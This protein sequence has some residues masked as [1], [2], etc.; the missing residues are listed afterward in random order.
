MLPAALI[1]FEVD[2]FAKLFRL[3]DGSGVGGRIRIADGE[4]L[5]VVR[6]LGEHASQLDLP[7]MG[8]L[9]VRLALA[10][11]CAVKGAGQQWV[12]FPPGN[13][14]A[15]PGSNRSSRGGNEAAG[16]S[17]VEGRAGDSASMQAV[18]E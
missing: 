17:G 2:S 3:L 4:A 16:A 1:V 13:W 5:L 15:P 10:T 14:F 9:T 18:M 8:R 6:G 12:K 11:Q 7:C